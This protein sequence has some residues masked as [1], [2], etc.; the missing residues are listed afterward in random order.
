MVAQSDSQQAE[1]V[2][3]LLQNCP[4]DPDRC[5]HYREE[6]ASHLG[7]RQR[8]NNFSLWEPI[9]WITFDLFLLRGRI[10]RFYM[11]PSPPEGVQLLYLVLYYKFN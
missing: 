8:E 3:Q 6:S 4:S 1:Q 10:M 2:N 7:F 11:K 9:P 5:K